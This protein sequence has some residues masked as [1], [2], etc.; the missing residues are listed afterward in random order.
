MKGETKPIFKKLDSL[1]KY[2]PFEWISLY[3]GDE[4]EPVY[5]SKYHQKSYLILT[6]ITDKMDFLK[7]NIVIYDISNDKFTESLRF[8]LD[9]AGSIHVL[10]HSIDGDKYEDLTYRKGR[11]NYFLSGGLTLDSIPKLQY[12]G[13]CA[14]VEIIRSVNDLDDDGINDL[15]IGTAANGIPNCFR[16]IKGKALPNGVDENENKAAPFSFKEPVPHPVHSSGSITATIAEPSI[17]ALTL[18]TI[19]GKYITKLFDDF[20]DI[21]IQILPFTIA[22]STISPGS[23]ILRLSNSTHSIERIIF[24]TR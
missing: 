13:D 8:R 19:E 3:R 15:V 5:Q 18:Y 10:T 23:Y 11:A 9:S 24:I 16:I 22:P 1:K 12:K 2:L 7:N 6:E 14:G 17:Y 21:G 4:E 20:L